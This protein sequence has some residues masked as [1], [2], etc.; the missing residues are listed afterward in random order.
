[1]IESTI[2]VTRSDQLDDPEWDAFLESS[3]NGEYQQ[4]SIWARVK[5]GEGWRV[6]RLMLREAGT[7]LSGFQL[8]WRESKLGRIGYVSRGPVI[9]DPKS[10]CN[11]LVHELKEAG[12]RLELRFLI[13]Q[14]PEGCQ[15]IESEI[16]GDSAF[17]PNRLHKV[18]T[19]TWV[20]PLDGGIDN[21]VAG[22][23]R[24]TRQYLASARRR[25]VSV[26][27]GDRSDLGGFFDL[28]VKTCERQ[29]VS[30]NPGNL[31]SFEALWD[32]F[33]EDG[34]IRLGIATYE[35]RAISAALSLSFGGRLC[36]WKK[37]SDP[38]YL[39]LHSMEILYHDAMAWGCQRDDL[40]CDYGSLQQATAETL[41]AGKPLT[42]AMKCTRDFFN[43]RFGGHAVLQPKAQIYICNPLLRAIYRST[44]CT[45]F[46]SK[47][48]RSRYEW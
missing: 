37:G 24:R 13:V 3:P 46:G 17:L 34:R 15:G 23:G 29:G 4:S 33:S 31:A 6:D 19:A 5:A 8:L 26:E 32:S 38:D 7:I 10:S 48:I 20:T 39:S 36:I 27:I 12:C 18:I 44:A 28:M 22:I 43:M 42:S 35:G 40:I 47:L 11:S 21:V 16:L 1:M 25:G 41:I 30:P 14:P 9:A 2:E 45:F